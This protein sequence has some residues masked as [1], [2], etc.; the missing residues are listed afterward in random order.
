MNYFDL[1]KK[2]IFQT[3]KRAPVLFVKGS[4]KYL[5][6]NKGKKYLDFF[7]G[8]SVSSIGHCHP[9]IVKAIKT[10]SEKLIHASNLYYTTPQIELAQSLLDL[11]LGGKVFF[12]NS[13]AEANECAI[14]LARKLG[15]K[16]GKN[17]IVAFKN[18]FHGR[19]I[20]TLSATGQKKFH[21]G[22][23]PLLY[24]FKF[25][26]FNSL[27]SVEKLISPKTCA[28][29]VEPIQGEGGV[30]PAKKEFLIG[31]RKLCNEN[32]LLLIFDEIQCGLGRTGEIFA[33]KNY[34][35]IPDILTLA[36]SLG[37][38][39]PV[40]ATIAKNKVAETF[41]F[42]DHGSTFGGNPVC[43]AAGIEVLKIVSDKKLLKNVELTGNYFLLKLKE[44]QKKY[45]TVKNVRGIGLM[46]GAELKINGKEIV[47]DCLQRGLL[48]NC[49]QDKVLRFLPPLNINRKDVNTAV[50][51]LTDVL[52]KLCNH[53]FHRLTQ[54]EK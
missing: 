27:F 10:Q 31:L 8:I 20:A 26:E 14:K 25:A 5:W 12:S 41:S 49:T 24:G 7:S 18:S 11:S 1:E 22:F 50:S 53:R 54:K 29:I 3:Y 30:Y 36:K 47:S 39:L 28:I 44:L 48:I 9:K 19:T 38:G 16:A 33:Y 2:Y 46:L 42:G 4:G 13:G 37:G 52:R 45:N 23:E 34:G 21:K 35:V 15:N 17:E 32:K 51:I 43:C 6:D 40:A